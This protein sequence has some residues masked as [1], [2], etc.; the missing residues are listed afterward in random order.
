MLIWGRVDLPQIMPVTYFQGCSA[1]SPG[2]ESRPLASSCPQGPGP[3]EGLQRLRALFE[4][5][6]VGFIFGHFI[7]GNSYSISAGKILEEPAEQCVSHGQKSSP[8]DSMRIRASL[9]FIPKAWVTI[10]FKLS[11]IHCNPLDTES[12]NRISLQHQEVIIKRTLPTTAA[13]H[14]E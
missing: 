11:C 4:P 9:F 5:C 3:F 12:A 13:L 14:A 8:G 1:W 7:F 6:Y 2:Q 10:T